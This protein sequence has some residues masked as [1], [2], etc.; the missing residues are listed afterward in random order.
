M[1]SILVKTRELYRNMM[2]WT[3][4]WW[5]IILTEVLAETNLNRKGKKM[6]DKYNSAFNLYLSFSVKSL[7]PDHPDY[8]VQSIM[9]LVTELYTCED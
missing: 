7:L 6:K 4:P 9:L 3:S 8:A 5:N 1:H 2:T